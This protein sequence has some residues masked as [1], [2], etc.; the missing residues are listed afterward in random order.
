VGKEAFRVVLRRALR[1]RCPR[2]GVGPIFQKVL[3]YSEYERCPAC[4]FVYDPK[5]ESIAF[6]YLSTAALTGCIGLVMILTQPESPFWG[7]VALVA[8]ALVVYLSTLPS[9]K[10]LAVAL[11]YLHSDG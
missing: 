5:G 6:M 2:C 10:A 1:L 11:N 7:R 9:R 4:G 3:R 8:G